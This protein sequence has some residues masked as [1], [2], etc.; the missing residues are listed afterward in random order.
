M[1]LLERLGFERHDER[2]ENPG[3]PLYTNTHWCLHQGRLHV[4]VSLKPVWGYRF[5]RIGQTLETFSLD[6]GKRVSGSHRVYS[7]SL[8]YL[9]VSFDGGPCKPLTIELR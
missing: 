5:F 1:S 6:T 3:R 8:G 7:F 2:I 4:T 9:Y